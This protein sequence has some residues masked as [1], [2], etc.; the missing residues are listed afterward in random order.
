MR[1]SAPILLLRPRRSPGLAAGILAIHGL[2]VL[3]LGLSALPPEA[4]LGLSLGLGGSAS[5]ALRGLHRVR[6]LQWGPGAGWQLVLAD[7]KPRR[8]LLDGRASRSLPWGVTL[9][10]RLQGGGRLR[11]ML[12]R[13]ALD[14]EAYRRLRVRL[15]IEA[16]GL[17]ERF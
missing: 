9:A 6:E 16:G 15:R 13:D 4:I 11:L 5:L 2:G 14:E 12:A 8:G 7:G 17:Q 10:F 3:G 1:D